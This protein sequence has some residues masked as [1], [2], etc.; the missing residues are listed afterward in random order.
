MKKQ[1]LVFLL[2]IGLVGFNSCEKE[3]PITTPAPEVIDNYLIFTVNQTEVEARF[4]VILQDE[5]FNG[6]EKAT[7]TIQ[8]QR[9][10]E[11]GNPQRLLFKLERID[12]ANTTFP[13]TLK[14]STDQS[15]PTIGATYVDESN[16][17]FGT[18]VNNP[19]DFSMTITSYENGLLQGTYA[20]TLFSGVTNNPKANITD[21]ELNIELVTY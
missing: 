1:L 12:L 19:D 11:N 6:Y 17:P 13:I 15:E 4:K 16:V 3:D 10:K 18:N 14:Y 21:G 7:H 9:L 2:L 20:G 8:I 5:V